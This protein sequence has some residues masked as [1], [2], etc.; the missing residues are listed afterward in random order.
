MSRFG[1]KEEDIICLDI[2]NSY[3]F[4]DPELL[5]IIKSKIREYL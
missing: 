5:D 2:I 1:L 3:A 4:N